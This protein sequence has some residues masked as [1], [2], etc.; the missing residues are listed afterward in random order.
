MNPRFFKWHGLRWFCLSALL[1]LFV[2]IITPTLASRAA[3]TQITR[4]FSYGAW[5]GDFPTTASVSTYEQLSGHHLD[6]GQFYIDWSSNFSFIQPY[7]QTLD[8]DHS[9]PMVTW[10]PSQYN[11]QQIANGAAD[12]YIQNFAIGV[13]NYGKPIQLRPMHE[14]NGNWYSWGI[15]DSSVNTNASYI[16]AWQHIVTIFR[17][18]GATNA[19]FIWSITSS[20]VGAGSSFTGAYPG[21]N[22]VDYVGVDGYNWGTTQS[23]GSTWQSFD[24]IFSAP[25]QALT[26]LT[27][28][29]ILIPEW[30]SAEIGG[31]KAAWITDAFQQLAS[32]KY[33]RVVGADWFNMN[34]ETDWRINSSSAALAA[35][36]AALGGSSP[37]P[38]PGITPTATPRVT[39]TATPKP[40]VTP[41]PVSGA[42]CKVSYTITSQWTGG[43]GGSIV[44]TNTGTATLTSW[45][46]KFSFANGQT[47]TQLWNGT[48]T[49]SGSAVTVTNL[50]YNGTL[51]PGANVS[52]GFNGTW[53]STNSIPTAFTLNGQKCA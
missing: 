14:M 42:S 34:K 27:S 53:N 46:L 24:Q 50:S 48:D 10:M 7:L 1:V 52:P 5:L 18:Q 16:K 6:V 26:Q 11:T 37:T 29:P 4:S 30:A 9:T 49:Q 21:D 35:Y 19:K 22:Y 17:Q 33:A 44:I 39:P 43:F 25:Y 23:W 47:I 28:K 15:G 12:S 40:T 36:Q 51:A 45:T 31:N 3:S 8:A 13:R 32:S 20:N 38:T 41:T 2:T